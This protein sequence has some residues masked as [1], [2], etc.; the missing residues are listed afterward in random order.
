VIEQFKL[1]LG[2][3]LDHADR[4]SRVRPAGL[5][6]VLAQGLSSE[7]NLSYLRYNRP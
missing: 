6:I 2:S 1:F 4:A 5:A 7:M 3:S